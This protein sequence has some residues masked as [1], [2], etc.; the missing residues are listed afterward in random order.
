[1]R[2]NELIHNFLYIPNEDL[3][4]KNASDFKAEFGGGCRVCKNSQEWYTP[5][6]QFGSTFYHLSKTNISQQDTCDS[7]CPKTTKNCKTIT[8][9]FHHHTT[10]CFD[11][12]R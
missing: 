5:T 1:M 12:S 2:D 8:V 9:V 10:T 6:A 4:K 7:Q 11:Y 3:A